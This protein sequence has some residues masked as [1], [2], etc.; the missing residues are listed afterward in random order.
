MADGVHRR[1]EVLPPVA[2]P[3]GVVSLIPLA[4]NVGLSNKPSFE[5]GCLHVGEDESEMAGVCARG[6]SEDADQ[7]KKIAEEKLLLITPKPPKYQ[8]SKEEDIEL[9]RADKE[10]MNQEEDFDAY[11]R[12][13][14]C[15]CRVSFEKRTTL[16]SM[17]FAHYT[18]RQIPF[19]IV[20]TE[21]T[22]QIFSF[23]IVSCELSWSLYVY[24]VVA[25][26]DQVDDHRNILF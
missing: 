14:E 10:K 5:S 20:T 21:A 15:S 9:T 18:P 16:S 19:D 12:D 7:L 23:K 13:I 26:R 8:Y 22:L 11:R 1:E 4:R 3:T 25:V 2:S 24:G 6:H 17:H